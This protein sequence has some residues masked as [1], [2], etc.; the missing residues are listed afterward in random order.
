MDLDLIF[1]RISKTQQI[2][3]S[4]AN[5]A[6]KADLE[7]APETAPNVPA[8]RAYKYKVRGGGGT[9]ITTAQTTEAVHRD[10]ERQCW[11]VL[12]VEQIPINDD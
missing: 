5:E 9:I 7:H 4:P 11:K 6:V 1:G 8:P 12:S 10:L 2:K 3:K